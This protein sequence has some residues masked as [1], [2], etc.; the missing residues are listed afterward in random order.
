MEFTGE[1]YLPNVSH[2]EISYEHWHRYMYST[3]FVKSK[4]VLDI[5]CGEGFGS[6]YLATYANSVTGVDIDADTILHAKKK[7]IKSNLNYQIGN[8]NDLSRFTDNSFDVV[9]SFE[10]IEHLKKEEQE[11]FLAEIFRVL[12]KNG[13]LLMSTPDKAKY[14]DEAQ[15]TNIF[16]VREFYQNEYVTFLQQFFLN[17][18]IFSQDIYTGSLIKPLERGKSTY[19]EYKISYQNG[20]YSPLLDEVKTTY[21][22]AVCSKGN[23]KNNQDLD[24]SFLYDPHQLQ[25]SVN[26]EK[27]N[28]LKSSIKDYEKE[29]EKRGN[30]QKEYSEAMNNQVE[31]LL[32]E[33]EKVRGIK[34]IINQLKSVITNYLT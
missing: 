31:H 20:Q 9:I 11:I 17:V 10:T 3:N 27:I 30:L 14:T 24:T 26:E 33:L 5:A 21:Y 23:K 2:F 12:N 6:N 15:H 8:C 1:R 34:G 22:I 29:L 7:Y 32:A 13:M 18:E 25:I 4:K 19:R 28:F 16:H